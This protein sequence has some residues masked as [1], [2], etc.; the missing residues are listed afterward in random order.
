MYLVQWSDYSEYKDST[1]ELFK[2][3]IMVFESLHKFYS[4]NP[5]IL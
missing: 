2:Y 4:T 1:E 3:M 5:E